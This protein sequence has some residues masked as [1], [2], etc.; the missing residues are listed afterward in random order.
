MTYTPEINEIRTRIRA[1]LRDQ[2][3]QAQIIGEVVDN[4]AILQQSVMNLAARV[5]LLENDGLSEDL[6]PDGE[7]SNP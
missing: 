6:S 5:R 1:I 2:A 3:Q 7:E 4:I